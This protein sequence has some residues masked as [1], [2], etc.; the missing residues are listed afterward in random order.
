MKT[1]KESGSPLWVVGKPIKHSLSPLIHNA[2]FESLGMKHRYFAL[3]VGG[4]ELEDFL[5]I[6]EKTQCPGA[7]L[8]LPLKQKILELVP[9]K[10]QTSTVKKL[11]AA[12]TLYLTREG[13]A[14]ENTDLYGF[15]KMVEKWQKIIQDYPVLVL[16]AGGAARAC[17]L[18]LEELGCPEILLWNRTPSRAVELKKAFPGLPL[19]VLYSDDFERLASDARMVVNATSLGLD[20]SDPSPFP[21]DLIEPSMVGVDLIYNRTTEFISDFRREGQAATGGLEMLVFQA[22]RS[23]KFWFDRKPDVEVMLEVARKKLR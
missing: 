9:P 11:G 8:T 14:L 10:N 4:D 20:G 12:N 3:E 21:S 17:V 22:A 18:G 23:W 5:D 6:F 19:T 16:G 13:P 15:K 7:N 2:A 1:V